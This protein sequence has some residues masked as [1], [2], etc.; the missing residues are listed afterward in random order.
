DA[1]DLRRDR[2]SRPGTR[3][4]NR[5]PRPAPCRRH[6]ARP[7]ILLRQRPQRH[8]RNGGAGA[9][10]LPR[11]QIPRHP[12]HGRQGDPVAAAA[13]PRH[14]HRPCCR[15]AGDDGGCKG[16]GT[17][18]HQGGG[19]DGADQP[20]R[21]GPELDR[22]RSGSASAGRATDVAG[23]GGGAGRRRL[24]RKRGRRSEEAVARRLLRRAG[25][26]ARGEPER[27]P[28]K[29]DDAQKG[30]RQRRFNP[31]H[32][33]ADYPGRRPGPGRTRDRGD[34]L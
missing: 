22:P 9:P 30:A 31:G 16:G 26:A 10:D 17:D 27:R 19:G 25:R 13:Q 29:G 15:R 18:R 8:P 12:E 14:P 23:K 32:R 20:R 24:L 6:Q 2:H 21:I 5:C 3:Q 11:P 1:A 34:A 28:E 33:S 4:A 7:R